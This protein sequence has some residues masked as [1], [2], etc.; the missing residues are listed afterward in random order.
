M[1][2]GRAATDGAGFSPDR[3][4]SRSMMT[5]SPRSFSGGR[6]VPAGLVCLL[7]AMTAVP[8]W[9]GLRWR[10]GKEPVDGPFIVTEYGIHFRLDDPG[11][12]REGEPFDYQVLLDAGPMWPLGERFALGATAYA[13]LK[14]ETA[15]GIAARFRWRPGGG[16]TAD[17]APG[18]SL[19][20]DSHD[21]DYDIEGPAA[22]ARL[23]VGWDDWIGLTLGMEQ[24]RVAGGED[25]IDW[26]LGGQLGSYPA[27]I[28][29]GLF[30]ALAVALSTSGGLGVTG[31][32]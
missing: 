28:V 32:H 8:A 16:V 4:E 9:A 17:F 7:V 29:A 14:E 12:T 30:L 27:A 11:D 25:E 20:A 6:F 31:S 19:V 10:D 13:S 21:D 18:V 5:F 3:D 24:V 26:Y 2:A 15:L 1:I 22:T 23:L